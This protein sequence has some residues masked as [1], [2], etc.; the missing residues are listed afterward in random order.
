MNVYNNINKHKPRNLCPY[1]YIIPSGLLSGSAFKGVN[2]CFLF[3]K[4]CLFI[5]GCAGS[6]FLCTGF[7]CL[8]RVRAVLCCGV[9]LLVTVSS[10]CGAWILGAQA[11]LV[12][13]S[14]AQ[15]LQWYTGF[16]VLRHVEFSQSGI[17]NINF[18]DAY[19]TR[20]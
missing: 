2:H 6:S 3:F 7:L 9:R 16:V 18:K 15:A 19:V 8:Q 20:E 11:S 5:F 17:I 13:G 1:N 14:R 10:L 4:F 12:L